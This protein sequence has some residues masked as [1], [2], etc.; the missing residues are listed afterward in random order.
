MI[1][2]Y[3]EGCEGECVGRCLEDHPLIL[4][5]CLTVVSFHSYMKP[6][7]GGSPSVA[8]PTTRDVEPKIFLMAPAPA[9]ECNF[10]YLMT[11]APAPECNFFGLGAGSGPF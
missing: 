2:E 3:G 9:P 8:K 7:K 5:R 6:L 1:L 4:T 11:P 10:F